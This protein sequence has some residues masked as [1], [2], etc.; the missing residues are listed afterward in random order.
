M[1][2]GEGVVFEAASRD[3]INDLLDILLDRAWLLET[4]QCH[5]ESREVSILS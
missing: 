2:D 3:L 5:P 1:A 4:E